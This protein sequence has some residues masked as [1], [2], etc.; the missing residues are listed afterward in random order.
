LLFYHVH[1]ILNC[2]K[3]TKL[4]GE[5]TFRKVLKNSVLSTLHGWRKSFLRNW[6]ILG[7]NFRR[8]CSQAG[9]L[10]KETDG[11]KDEER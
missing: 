3:I 5:I 4:L 6:D 11:S 9:A 10:R 1:R 8:E 7:N 2:H